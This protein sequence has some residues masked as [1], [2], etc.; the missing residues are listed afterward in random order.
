MP[1]I[2]L[3]YTLE[4]SRWVFQPTAWRLALRNLSRN[5]RRNMATGSALALGFAGLLALMGFLY[6]ID[7]YLAA[8]T[9]YGTQIGH[10]TVFKSQGFERYAMEPKAYS[11]SPADQQVIRST[12]A[13]HPEIELS[14]GQLQGSGLISNGC[15]TQPFQARGTDP[16]TAQALR[17]HKE[18]RRWNVPMQ[19]YVRGQSAAD[20]P[21]D[22]NPIQLSNTLAKQLN[23]QKLYSEFDQHDN[24]A[25]VP[26]CTAL[27]KHQL[28]SNVQLLTKS[29]ADA[30][31]IQDA[32]VV[33]VFSGKAEGQKSAL[34]MALPQ[35]QKLLDT[36]HVSSYGLWLKDPSRAPALA[37]T[38]A[39][40]LRSAGLNVDIY[41]WTSKQTNPLYAGTMNFLRIMITFLACVLVAIVV[42]SIFNA[43][44]MTAI[45]R[46]QE[47][48][49]MRSLGFERQAL[50]SLFGMEILLLSL[51][52]I[53]LGGVIGFIGIE[54]VQALKIRLYPPGLEGGME[55][56]LRPGFKASF[57]TAV[58]LVILTTLTALAVQRK[59]AQQRII[60]LLSA[61]NR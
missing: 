59:I 43:S 49:M 20:L 34:T 57:L 1:K 2:L 46:S 18:L 48:G 26:D 38:L 9:V 36:E 7:S 51:I 13:R 40:E 47:T 24:L 60:N 37:K 17:Q 52:S 23:K 30:M 61:A 55:L 4:H 32:E 44:T 8:Y 56:I 54:G 50:T 16:D 22:L 27:A 3:G 21:L 14:S 5:I 6:S 41:S 12:L 39:Q 31:S 35:L 33:G 58:G 45:E 29:W 28:D 10:L 19:S 11:F 42:F 25:V 53:A 15:D